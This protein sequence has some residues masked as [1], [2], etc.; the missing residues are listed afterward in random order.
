MTTSFVIIVYIAALAALTQAVIP[1][2][3]QQSVAAER[4]K[5]HDSDFLINPRQ[6]SV[7]TTPNFTLRV[8]DFN[9]YPLLAFPDVQ[10]FVILATVKYEKSVFT[11]YHPRATETLTAIRGTF[12]VQ[13]IFE[14]LGNARVVDI[15]VPPGRTTVFPQGLPHTTTCKTLT[16]CVF[17][18]IF[19]SA[20]PGLI[21]F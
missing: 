5:L 6:G 12:S 3:G 4:A 19:N 7:T 13:I 21:P 2:F 11:H 17:S 14:G 15:M 18:A 9:T 1:S 10:S 20:D 16:G 8:A